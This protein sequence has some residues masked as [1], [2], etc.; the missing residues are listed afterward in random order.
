MQRKQYKEIINKLYDRQKSDLM[1]K[2]MEGSHA[3]AEAVKLSEPKVIASYPITPQTHIVEKLAE[4]IANGELDAELLNVESEHSAISACIGAQAMGARTFTASSSQGL[5]LMHE[6]LFIASGMRLPIVMAVANRS[7]SAP[8]N[9]WCDWSDAMAE[10]D[11]G[12]IQLYCENIQEAF[13]TILM[14]Y[15]IAED[16][17]VMLPAMVCIDGFFLS[18]VFEPIDITVKKFLRPYNKKISFDHPITQGAWASPEYYQDF[19][20][21]QQDGMNAAKK[22]ISDVNK[23][24][25]GRK[26]GNG[27]IEVTNPG[28]KYAIVSMGSVCGTI[29]HFLEKNDN[30]TLIRIKSFRPFPFEELKILSDFESIGVLEKDISL[31]NYGAL[32]TEIKSITTVPV[33]N[34]VGGL[35]GRDITMNDIQKIF[36]IIKKKD[37]GFHWV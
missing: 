29:K 20:R 14:A 17:N 12:W 26:Y 13:D 18:H 8:L 30:F 5:A 37:K 28:K 24:F 9:I 6:I 34:F 2:I 22:V 19:K 10:R 25:Y 33:C 31:G 1:K 32:F 11:S 35:G 21:E 16:K 7:L 15:R 4:M 3:I 23:E 36:E 27:L